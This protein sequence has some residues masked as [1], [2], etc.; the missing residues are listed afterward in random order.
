MKQYLFLI[1]ALFAGAVFAGGC[2]D[3]CQADYDYWVNVSANLLAAK[4]YYHG[5]MSTNCWGRENVPAGQ[6]DP[7]WKGLPD[8]EALCESG[9]GYSAC[10]GSC[11]DEYQ[12]CCHQSAVMN[13]QGELDQCLAQCPNESASADVCNKQCA[14]N[15]RL[16]TY[17][18]ECVRKNGVF[19]KSMGGK[20]K[21]R[22]LMTGALEDITPGTELTDNSRKVITGGDGEIT[23]ELVGLDGKVTEVTLGP[24]Q[25][26]IPS[27]GDLIGADVVASS[28]HSSVRGTING[29]GDFIFIMPLTIGL[30]VADIAPPFDDRPAV[31]VTSEPGS[32][33]F[34]IYSNLSNGYVA[35]ASSDG[36]SYEIID[37]GSGS[38]T[39]RSISG[40]VDVVGSNAPAKSVPAGFE[41]SAEPNSISE[42][43]ETGG[44]PEPG[45][46]PACCGSAAF[47]LLAGMGAARAGIN[48]K[49]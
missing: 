35:T 29:G 31:T 20:V 4:S 17:S 34:V 32:G 41:A 39:V 13:A 11:D 15:E 48:I 47:V 16:L 21:V 10:M 45:P 40:T 3:R 18:C 44:I 19:I 14:G 23:I 46:S 22:N 43:R 36:S 9:S 37:S 49:R 5:M 42:P 28:E 33:K 24:R 6:S 26:F 1:L 8:C 12:A 38:I 27:V 30:P 7:C 25:Y 2:Q